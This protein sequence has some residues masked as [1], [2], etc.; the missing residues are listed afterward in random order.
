MLCFHGTPGIHDGHSNYFNYLTDAGIGV[1]TPSRPGYGRTPLSSGKSH[2]EAADLM[3]AL[4]DELNIEK[5][6]V[7]GISGGGPTTLNFALRH[8]DRCAGCMTEV[9]VSGNFKHPNFEEL[10]KW[11]VKMSV[12][13]PFSSR[14][15]GWMAQRSPEKILG[16]MM[17]EASL[18]KGEEKDAIAKEIANDP[19]RTE[20][21][22]RL[23]DYSAG[24]S[25]YPI[26]AEGFVNDLHEFVKPIN[27]EGI[28]VP[29]LVVHGNMDGDI[30][31][32]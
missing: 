19:E 18:F 20:R 23:M 13:S 3:A 14:M 29:T 1:I 32:A 6:V 15:G 9:A 21:L 22:A 28:T 8:P 26:T 27:F 10:Q 31:F 4:L 24:A 11:Y 25:L 2:E 17:A 7:Y 5:V 30:P 12:T 16:F